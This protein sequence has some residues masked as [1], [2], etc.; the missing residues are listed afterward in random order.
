MEKDPTNYGLEEF[1]SFEG[2]SFK[3]V[4]GHL[5][6]WPVLR[7]ADFG[8]N[9]IS[10]CKVKTRSHYYVNGDY[11]SHWINM[12]NLFSNNNHGLFSFLK[13]D[14][15]FLFS[16][17][18]ANKFFNRDEVGDNPLASLTLGFYKKTDQTL[19]YGLKG[20]FDYL[21]KNQI[22]S[23]LLNPAIK[24]KASSFAKAFGGRFGPQP[25][26]GDPFI[27]LHHPRGD[28]KIPPTAVL[29]SAFLQPNYSRWPGDRSG[30]LHP[31]LH[32]T[33]LNSH[34]LKKHYPQAGRPLPGESY[35]I[36]DFFH[37]IF[38]ESPDDPLARPY[39]IPGPD[40]KK[41]FMRMMEL[42]AVYP[43]A[44]D[45]SHYSIAG[46]YMKT[47]FPR[48]CKL[49]REGGSDC[50]SAARNKI[51]IRGAPFRA[52]IRGD[53]GWPETDYYMNL[54][55]AK[56]GVD[57]SVATYFLKANAG[58][59]D[60]NEITHFKRNPVQPIQPLRLTS[61]K[62]FYPW[63]VQELP[64]HLL[65]SWAPTEERDRYFKYRFPKKKFLKCSGSAAKDMPVPS[66][67]AIGGRSDY[68]VK[69]ISCETVN[70][71]DPKPGNIDE[72]C[73]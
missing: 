37:L 61:G 7:Y 55:Q 42:M 70:D 22:F 16:F 8:G 24:F 39:G 43:D 68:S 13:N 47:Y 53:F 5:N 1:N 41:N 67:C 28:P 57:I 33:N 25:D 56:K 60:P 10:L 35:Y 21:S 59:I 52:Y 73:P 58:K 44:F 62:I 17:N 49:I 34:F 38:Y 18:H 72:Y 54:N 15:R 36:E 64:A 23:L 6:V 12:L 63:L 51:N 40:R 46:N 3:Y 27:P 50:Q 4:F 69:L 29:N 48:I 14:Q 26:Q 11:H 30:L 66:S 32:S 45:L 9:T 65:S 19:Y 2:K 31:Q 71:L 20:D